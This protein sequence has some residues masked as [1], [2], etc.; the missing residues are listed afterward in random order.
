MDEWTQKATGG[1]AGIM[2]GRLRQEMVERERK[3]HRLTKKE[4]FSTN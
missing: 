2:D 3:R 1:A 4:C